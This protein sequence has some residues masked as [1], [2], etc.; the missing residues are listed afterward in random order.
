MNFVS[1]DC[2]STG[3]HKEC[4][5]LTVA[6]VAFDL[7]GILDELE[8]KILPPNGIFSVDPKALEVNKIDLAQ[9][10][11]EADPL[12]KC[13][14]K[15]KHFLQMHTTHLSPSWDGV[16][17]IQSYITRERL[18]PVGSQVHGDIAWIKDKI[19]PAWS[20]F[21]SHKI[22]ETCCLA[23]FL[24]LR[25]ELDVEKTGLESLA[26]HFGVEYTPHIAL[27]EAKA[28]A[29]VYLKLLNIRKEK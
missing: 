23:E 18:I 27:D 14:N 22:Q 5:I 25:G 1:V 13:Q 12:D 3:V 2:E 10:L 11:L 26:K 19:F 8:V 7:N 9:H 4:D 20:V 28:C 24:K 16:G 29:Q 17:D 21:V 6:L 15:I